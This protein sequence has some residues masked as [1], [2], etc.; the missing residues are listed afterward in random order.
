MQVNSNNQ[1]SHD[2]PLSVTSIKQV[3]NDASFHYSGTRPQTATGTRINQALI[4]ERKRALDD[5]DAVLDLRTHARLVA[6]LRLD[7][8]I[9]PLPPPV[10]PVGAVA[11]PRSGGSD[12]ITVALVGPDLPR[13][14]SPCRAA[15]ARKAV[16]YV[17]RRDEH[18]MN[19]LLPTIDPDVRLHSEV[20]L[21]ALVFLDWMSRQYGS[22]AV[23]EQRK[24]TS[25]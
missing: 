25:R 3:S 19:E 11:S 4:S 1:V 13:R 2:I 14:R 24:S 6:I 16:G 23:P 8:L 17:H 12:H 9:D 21:L 5:P 20:P 22:L 15:G 7:L 18:R 10:A